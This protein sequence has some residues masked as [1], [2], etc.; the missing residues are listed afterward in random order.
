[1]L[2][3]N[4]RGKPGKKTASRSWGPA[5]VLLCTAVALL[6]V[7]VV[8]IVAG[9][10]LTRT[11]LAPSPQ[12]HR[13]ATAPG[14]G[15]FAVGEP[16]RANGPV[17]EVSGVEQLGGPTVKDLA[18][19]NHG[20]ANQVTPDQVQVE[21]TVRIVND[22]NRVITYSPSQLLLRIGKAAGVKATSSTFTRGR[23][24]PGTSVEGNLGF[25]APRRGAALRL[26]LPSSH[27]PILI[28]LGRADSAPA[29][30]ESH[31]H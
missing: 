2:A 3:E 7:L 9:V 17:V 29:S 22:S 11:S 21:V 8:L 30:G 10:E 6:V 4:R 27:G 12:S 5:V 14:S 15:P 1:M 31:D 13:I 16:V 24:T 18:N 26:Q 20:I 25:V 23:L 19:V 28:D